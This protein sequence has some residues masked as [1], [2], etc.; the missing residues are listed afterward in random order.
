MH[1]QVAANAARSSANPRF[2]TTIIPRVKVSI[3]P[4]CAR[5]RVHVQAQIGLQGQRRVRRLATLQTSPLKLQVEPL[6]NEKYDPE[7]V[8]VRAKHQELIS[9]MRKLFEQQP[10]YVEQLRHVRSSDFQVCVIMVVS[11]FHMWAQLVCV[12]CEKKECYVLHN[13]VCKLVCFGIL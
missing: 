10:M 13:W 12:L 9:T 3:K 1:D 8:D 7:A 5:V 6:K 2:V 11:D 4:P